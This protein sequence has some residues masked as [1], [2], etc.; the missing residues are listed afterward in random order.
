M[1]DVPVIDARRD[2]A[3]A[4]HTTGPLG[5][6]RRAYLTALPTLLVALLSLALAYPSASRVVQIGPDIVEYIDIARRLVAGQGYTLGI[7]A[8]HVGPP[9]VLQDGLIHRPPLYTLLVAG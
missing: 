4:P 7:R 5:L 6:S 8:Y 2:R 1:P 9:E 3:Q